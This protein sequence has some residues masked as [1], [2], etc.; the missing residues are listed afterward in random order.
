MQCNFPQFNTSFKA[1]MSKKELDS[2]ASA[3]QHFSDCYLISTVESL[4]QTE[5]GRK[6]LQSQIRYDT[7]NPQIINCYLYNTSGKREKF[8]VHSQKAQKGYEEVYRRQPNKF[9]RSLDISINEYEKKYHTKP[10][11]SRLAA[12][13]RTFNFEFGV[14]SQ[15][16][17]TLTGIQPPVNIAETDLN[18]N[19]K[20]YKGKVLELFKRMDKDKNH[21]LVIGTG[22]RPLDGK[23]WHAYVLQ[24]VDLKAN[25]VWV[26]NKRGNKVRVMTVDEVLSR[27]KYIVG[28]FNSD[29]V[30]R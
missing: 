14:P 12:M 24:D 21:S 5:N 22:F 8:S 4:S 26:K 17:K 25:K 6:I 2:F 19:L 3:E 20:S 30:K 1:S 28:Y 10:W 15:F 9:L 27:F 16:M 29:L 18:L 13:I 7:H 23:K 11:Y